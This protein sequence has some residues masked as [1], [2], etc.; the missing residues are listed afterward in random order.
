M[1]RKG[2]RVNMGKTKCKIS[3]ETSKM[4]AQCIDPCSIC[5]GRAKKNSVLCVNCGLWVGVR[6]RCSGIRG[7]FVK[8]SGVFECKRCVEGKTT[9]GWEGRD[10]GRSGKVESFVYLGDCLS[11]TGGCRKA[12]TARVRAGWKEFRDLSSILRGKGWTLEQQQQA[13]LRLC[14]PLCRGLALDLP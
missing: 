7:S 9:V 2:L 6:K 14:S 13:I 8:V 3:G 1:E 4:E 5:R 10:G 11:S 12:V